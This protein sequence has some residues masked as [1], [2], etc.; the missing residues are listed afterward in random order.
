MIPPE[1]DYIQN[2]SSSVRHQI[3]IFLVLSDLQNTISN[4]P[5]RHAT[6]HALDG[7]IRMSAR[8]LPQGERQCRICFDEYYMEAVGPLSQK[9]EDGESVR[10][11]IVPVCLN[12]TDVPRRRTCVNF[13]SKCLVGIHLVQHVSRNGSRNRQYV[14]SVVWRWSPVPSNPRPWDSSPRKICYSSWRPY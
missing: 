6:Q 5:K 13:L 12:V 4:P 8:E 3:A 14:H 7:L 11:Y 10:K 1:S 2:V 9:A